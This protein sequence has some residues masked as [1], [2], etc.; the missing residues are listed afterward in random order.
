MSINIMKGL[1]NSNKLVLT[2]N[3]AY[4]LNSRCSLIQTEYW[5]DYI[6]WEMKVKSKSE[7]DMYRLCHKD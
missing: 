1:Y 3:S 7:G 5:P 2:S 6:V 4:S